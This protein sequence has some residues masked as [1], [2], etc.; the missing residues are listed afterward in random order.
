[1]VKKTIS[2]IR[3]VH[4]NTRLYTIDKIFIIMDEWKYAQH[5]PTFQNINLRYASSSVSFFL[6][7]VWHIS[8]ALHKIMPKIPM[9]ILKMLLCYRFFTLKANKYCSK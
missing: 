4:Q 5:T 8:D 3:V 2:K 9:L 1:M 6:V 7:F